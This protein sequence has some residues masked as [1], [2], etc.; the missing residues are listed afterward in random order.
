MK[1]NHYFDKLQIVALIAVTITASTS[2][3]KYT[4][5]EVET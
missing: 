4:L 1:I 3:K 5:L 2:C